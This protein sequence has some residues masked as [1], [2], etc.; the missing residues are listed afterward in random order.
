MMM[1]TSGSDPRTRTG[2]LSRVGGSLVRDRH[3]GKNV[4]IFS[5]VEANSEV[6]NADSFGVLLTLHAGSYDWRFVSEPG[7]GFADAGSGSCHE[8]V[9]PLRLDR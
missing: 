3:R 8:R 7:A 9:R 5:K 4:H 2:R 1:I 6:R